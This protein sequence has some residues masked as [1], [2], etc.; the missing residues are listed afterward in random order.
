MSNYGMKSGAHLAP[1]GGT[2]PYRFREPNYQSYRSPYGPQ[3]KV[4][5]HMGIMNRTSLQAWGTMGIGFGAV[6]GIFALFFFDGVPKVR[7]DILQKIPIIGDF[8][9]H[10]V[11]P[12]DNP[13]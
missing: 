13:F 2:S 8:Y 6:A 11:P 3:Y 1:G 4:G 9:V 5:A 7:K 10:E 12:E